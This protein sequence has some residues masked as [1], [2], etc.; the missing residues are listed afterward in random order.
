VPGLGT[1]F[2]TDGLKGILN[3]VHTL[4]TSVHSARPIFGPGHFH[5]IS[6]I[7]AARFHPTSLLCIHTGNGRAALGSG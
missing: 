1:C 4:P 7:C 6:K 2:D 5:G 3:L